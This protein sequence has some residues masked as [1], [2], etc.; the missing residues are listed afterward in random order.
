MGGQVRHCSIEDAKK[1]I[2]DDEVY[3]RIS[4]DIC[5]NKETLIFPENL[6]YIGGYVDDQI[7]SAAVVHGS[8]YGDMA[9]FQVLK[10]YRLRYARELLEKTLKLCPRP[11]YAEFP[12]LYKPY[13]NFVKKLGFKEI[14]MKKNEFLKNGN[15]YDIHVLVLEN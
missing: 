15:V 6:L 1:I 3:D 5:P 8:E 9:H 10:D 7:V 4:D 12:S 11:L 2:L 13:M 14:E